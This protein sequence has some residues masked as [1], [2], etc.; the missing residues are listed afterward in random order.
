ML[1]SVFY[2][3]EMQWNSKLW[4]HFMSLTIAVFNGLSKQ[5]LERDHKSQQFLVRNLIFQICIAREN[6]TPGTAPQASI[7]F[8][9]YASALSFRILALQR[10]THKV[11]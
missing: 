8:A 4:M 11:R 10:E 9:I 2:E 3:I 7:C 1:L 5:R 6:A